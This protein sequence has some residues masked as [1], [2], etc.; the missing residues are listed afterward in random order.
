MRDYTAILHKGKENAI[1]T[2]V[3]MTMLGFES[4]QNLKRE[5]ARAR[6]EGQIILSSVKGGYYL[7]QDNAEIEVWIKTLTKRAKTTLQ[8]LENAKNYLK[9][10]SFTKNTRDN[11][12]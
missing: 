8:T 7:P 1:K 5:I 3:L 12:D 11:S 6:E 10:E 2:S 4:E 9:N